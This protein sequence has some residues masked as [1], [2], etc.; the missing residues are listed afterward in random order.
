MTPKRGNSIAEYED[1]C[2]YSQLDSKMM[3]KQRCLQDRY[4]RWSE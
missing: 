4:G 3:K 2:K 1:V